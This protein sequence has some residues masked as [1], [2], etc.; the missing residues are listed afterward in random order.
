MNK[1]IK[2]NKI[3]LDFDTKTIIESMIV[4]IL[5]VLA[6]FHLVRLNH[7]VPDS[8]KGEY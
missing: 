4:G 7:F 1:D 5:F 8:W 6:M 3:W 2:Y